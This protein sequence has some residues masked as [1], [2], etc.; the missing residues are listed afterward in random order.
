MKSLQLFF[1]ALFLIHGVWS[2]FT[3]PPDTTADPNTIKTCTWWHVAESS[4]SCASIV[5]SYGI[6]SE[7]FARWNPSVATACKLTAGNSYCI[8]NNFGQD[9]PPQPSTSS[10]TLIGT[11]TVSTTASPTTGNGISTPTPIQEGMVGNCNKFHFVQSGQGCTTIGSTYGV[12]LAQLVAW[13][14]AIGSQCTG[15]WANTYLCVGVVGS[16]T[17]LTT[18]TKA[19]TTTS[20]G[21][22]ITT[23]TPTQA[24]MVSNCDRFH[25]VKSG[26][27]CGTIASTYGITLANFYGWNPAVGT[28][29]ESLW[30]DTYV[31]VRTIGFVPPKTTTTTT[32]TTKKT[33]TTSAGGVATP[34]PTQPGMVSGCKKFHKVASGDQCGTIA[35]RYSISLASFYS[36]NP[37][38]GSSCQ[39]LWLDYYVCV[40]R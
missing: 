15:L 17:T 2:Q 37:A 31:C 19:A 18:T 20:S 40:G 36:W 3:V 4:D 5:S 30:L 38:V 33:T 35:T 32:T 25:L 12:S 21:N 6:T 10:P 24:G 39:T 27:Q 28:S 14:P 29:C 34:T 9:E 8:E 7:Q 26:D 23:P 13:N 1:G 22:G 11:T 16:S